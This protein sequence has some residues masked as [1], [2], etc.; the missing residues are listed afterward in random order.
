MHFKKSQVTM[1]GAV[2]QPLTNTNHVR[3]LE[4][5]EP[6]RRPLTPPLTQQ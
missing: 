6:L 3:I 1:E 4:H 2:E 5:C